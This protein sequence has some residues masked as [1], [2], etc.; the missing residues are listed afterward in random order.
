MVAVVGQVESGKSSL[1]SA[2]LGEMTKLEGN[3]VLSVNL[4][5]LC[6]DEKT[7]QRRF[8]SIQDLRRKKMAIEGGM[9]LYRLF[10]T[11]SFGQTLQLV[12]P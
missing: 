5:S 12:L 4:F 6:Y 1:L 2:I 10:Q 11:I 8:S 9:V 3:V 7:D